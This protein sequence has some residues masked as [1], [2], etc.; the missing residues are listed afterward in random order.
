[1]FTS[2]L[3]GY[4]MVMMSH[5][6]FTEIEDLFAEILTEILCILGRP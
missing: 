2:I 5:F 3:S 4:K 6:A 1:M